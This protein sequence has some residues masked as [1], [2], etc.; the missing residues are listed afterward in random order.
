M[1]ALF[2]LLMLAAL[3]TK[4]LVAQDAIKKS[5]VPPSVIEEFEAR[6]ADA[7]DVVWLRQGESLYGARFQVLGKNAEAIYTPNGE[8]VQTEQ[9]IPYLE[10]PDDARSYCRS[11]YPDYQAKAVKKVSTRKYGILYE[12]KVLG[13]AKTI[14]MTFDMHGK[15]ISKKEIEA[16][17][18]DAEKTE[19]VKDKLG[20]L[21][22]KNSGANA[23]QN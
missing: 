7:E 14:G 9:E 15:L 11:N 23:N 21:F 19:G 17:E 8:W 5:A 3:G 20:K 6:F 13:N 12:I 10:M 4:A 2:V 22:N 18:E 1:K 16:Q